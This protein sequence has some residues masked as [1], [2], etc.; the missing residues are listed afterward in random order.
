MKCRPIA[1]YQKNNSPKHDLT[2]HFRHPLK[3]TCFL[4]KMTRVVNPTLALMLNDSNSQL[5]VLCYKM[6]AAISD[7]LECPL[8]FLSI[9]FHLGCLCSEDVALM[10]LR[11][12][13]K[14]HTLS[15]IKDCDQGCQMLL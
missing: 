5:T 10:K 2:N 6:V 1:Q 7:V 3:A 11:S 15:K 4:L 8:L 13:E 12:H 9:Q 14:N